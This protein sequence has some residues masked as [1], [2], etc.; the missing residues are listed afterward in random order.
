MDAAVSVWSAC[1][2]DVSASAALLDF[3]SAVVGNMAIFMTLALFMAD[4]D[5]MG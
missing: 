5:D 2:V 3:G 4:I 1:F